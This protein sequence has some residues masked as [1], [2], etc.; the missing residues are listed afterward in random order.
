MI[1]AGYL[2]RLAAALDG[3]PGQVIVHDGT[4]AALASTEFVSEMTGIIARQDVTLNAA[5]VAGVLEVGWDES[6]SIDISSAPVVGGW[7]L[8]EDSGSDA[9]SAVLRSAVFAGGT[10]PDP[11]V[12]DLTDVAFRV[13]AGTIT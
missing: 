11:F 7:V 12:V 3:E 1:H 4:W 10:P 6:V 8:A 9:T 13:G 2:Q 5:V